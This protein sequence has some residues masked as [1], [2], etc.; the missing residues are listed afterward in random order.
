[1]ER[2]G[3]FRIGLMALVAVGFL[4]AGVAGDPAA[5][6]PEDPGLEELWDQFPLDA[7][8]DSP[9]EG[10]GSSDEAGTETEP[11]QQVEP[12][13]FPQPGGTD[14]TLGTPAIVAA[15]IALLLLGLLLGGYAV[16]SS[17]HVPNPPRVRMPA[18]PSV[19]GRQPV[20]AAAVA[21]AGWVRSARV[22]LPTPRSASIPSPD[23]LMEPRVIDDLLRAVRAAP[24]Q[25]KP[26]EANM[27]RKADR[28]GHASETEALKAKPRMAEAHKSSK[29]GPHA[30]A[31]VLKRKH[32]VDGTEALKAKGEGEGAL[33]KERLARSDAVALKEKLASPLNDAHA[34]KQRESP[35]RTRPRRVVPKRQ[36]ALRP[37][38]DPDVEKWA[39]AGQARVTGKHPHECEVRWWRGYVQSQFWAV[40]TDAGAEAT[41][42]LS[43]YFRW[44]KS[45][46]PP[47]TPASAAALRALVGSLEHEGWRV[48]G[49][50]EDWFAVRLAMDVIQEGD[51]NGT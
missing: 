44:R 38:P 24:Q 26:V 8:R 30:E 3:S 25:R 5:A 19:R 46:P 31:E 21:A 27:L 14:S 43:P 39:Q 23:P 37:V 4:A 48:V 12:R 50:G 42:A 13:S 20:R 16:L 40:S 9:A 45:T 15:G 34:K 47:E 51:R 36:S 2:F 22:A 10:G 29:A 6:A 32:P 18:R 7:E 41:I 28:S 35:V 17:G 33:D 49:R 11:T 1:L